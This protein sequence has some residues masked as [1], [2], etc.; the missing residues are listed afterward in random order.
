MIQEAQ[1]NNLHYFVFYKNNF[2][3]NEKPF[4]EDFYN[5]HTTKLYE[6]THGVVYKI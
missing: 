6:D 1:Q 2:A 3:K 4:N 5:Q